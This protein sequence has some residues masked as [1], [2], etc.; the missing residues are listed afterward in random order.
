[1]KKY[2]KS[3]SK[4]ERETE[5][6]MCEDVLEQLKGKEDSEILE[7]KD[8]KASVKELRAFLKKQLKILEEIENA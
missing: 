6:V 2:L 3:F 4:E 5:R 1:M 8:S 7:Y